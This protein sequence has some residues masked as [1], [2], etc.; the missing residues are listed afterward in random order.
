MKRKAT[1]PRWALDTSVIIALIK[2]D[3][4]YRG[5]PTGPR[6]HELFKRAE[7][8]EGILIVS[9]LALVETFKPHPKSSLTAPNQVEKIGEFFNHPF[10]EVVEVG[11]RTAQLS[12]DIAIED[13]LPSWDAIHV[14]SAIHGNADVMFSWDDDHLVSKREIRNLPIMHP[15]SLPTSGG[16]PPRSR[17]AN[18]LDLLET[19][20][21][22]ND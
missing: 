6:S 1:L 20:S 3:E 5:L 13:G 14:A 21:F 7:S 8:Q 18:L 19:Q 10:I 17:Q 15:P 9:A 11:R 2:G 4:H 22:E 16:P 12:R